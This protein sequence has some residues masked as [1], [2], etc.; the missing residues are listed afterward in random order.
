MPSRKI[1]P[2]LQQALDSVRVIGNEAVH[3]GTMD[4]RDDVFTVLSL[5]GLVNFIV[6][7]AITDEEKSPRFTRRCRLASWPELRS[8]ILQILSL[9]RCPSVDY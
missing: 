1:S 9:E 2:A 3:P 5:F 7:K 8:E 4:L 6:Q